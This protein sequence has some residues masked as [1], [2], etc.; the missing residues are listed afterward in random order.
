VVTI[1]TTSLTFSNSTFCPHS[2]FMCFVW[3]WE[4]TAIIS[5]YIII[6][7]VGML[8][9]ATRWGLGFEFLWGKT[10]CLLHTRPDRPWGPPRFF[11][12]ESQGSSQG[13]QRR[14]VESTTHPDQAPMIRL[15]KSTLLLPVVQ[16]WLAELD[17]RQECL[18]RG[19]NQ[20]FKNT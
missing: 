2:V 6:R 16:Q 17:K 19:T 3:I 18:Q 8:S 11:H 7:E 12:N 14:G 9:I 5:L 10:F 4:Q 20:I 13:I 15:S 1:C